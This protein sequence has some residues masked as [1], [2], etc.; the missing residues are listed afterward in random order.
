MYEKLKRLGLR[1]DAGTHAARAGDEYGIRSS[2]ISCYIL[3]DTLDSWTS[4]LCAT[5]V[6]VHLNIFHATVPR[7][8]SGADV[9]A[10][11]IAQNVSSLCSV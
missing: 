10:L 5:A 4:F 11:P 7:L 9:M 2:L 3:T 1:R 6:P 8:I